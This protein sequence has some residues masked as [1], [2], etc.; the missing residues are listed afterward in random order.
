MLLIE[1][2]CVFVNILGSSDQTGASVI[3]N[4]VFLAKQIQL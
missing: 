2:E 4:Q 1:N 3:I